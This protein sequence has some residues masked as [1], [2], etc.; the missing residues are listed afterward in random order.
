MT[1]AK[2]CHASS[3]M[4]E[5]VEAF[6]LQSQKLSESRCFNCFIIEL[7]ENWISF[8]NLISWPWNLGS[9]SLKII[10]NGIIQK[11]VYC[12]LFAFYSNYGSILH[13]FELKRDI[14]RTSR[15]FIPLAFHA[16]L[17]GSPSKY[18]HKVWYAKTRMVWPTDAENKSEDMITCFDRI[19]ER[20]R[21]TEEWTDE[22][23]P[24]YGIGRAYG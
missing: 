22:R 16:P 13:H 7:E 24:H 14:G 19:H 5:L 12:F 2:T 23:T 20:V 10:G 11:L 21:R 4:Q 1:L 3:M 9:G 15:F 6:I 17:R 18:R 8:W